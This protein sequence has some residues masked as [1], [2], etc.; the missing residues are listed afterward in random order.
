MNYLRWTERQCV[1]KLLPLVISTSFAMDIFVPAIPDMIAYFNSTNRIMQASL[2]AFMVTVAIAQ[3]F[4]GPLSDRYGRRGIGIVSAWLYFGG[5]FLCMLTPSVH[6][7]IFARVIQAIGA[8]GTYLTCFIVIRDNFDTKTCGRLFSLL[9]GLNAFI[10]STAPVIGGLLLDV[11]TTWRSGFCFLSG[12]GLLILYAVKR[13]IPH[14]PQP[15]TSTTIRGC[16][17]AYQSIFETPTFRQYAFSAS[18]GLLGL[19]L[20]C[21]LSPD[22]L[23]RQFHHTGTQYGLWFGLNA[24]TVFFANYLAAH[25]THRLPLQRIV[26]IGLCLIVLASFSMMALNFYHPNTMRFMLPMLGMTVGIGLSMGCSIAL[27]LQGFEKNAGTAT[28]LVSACQ[29][30]LAGILGWIVA[31]FSVTTVS[32]ALPVLL[33]AIMSLMWNLGNRSAILPQDQMA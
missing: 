9:T 13:N 8:C 3:L 10:A 18:T 28:A 19:Y 21:A 15:T 5:S 14:Y 33:F 23:I 30:A 17:R 24:L 32:L 27:S 16:F 20:F 31:E 12:L 11:T 1:I 7:L 4:I 22:I 25:L 2:Y 29:F 26:N 6:V